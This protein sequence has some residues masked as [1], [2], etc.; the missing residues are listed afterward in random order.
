MTTTAALETTADDGTTARRTGF[1]IAADGSY[2]ACLATD[3]AENWYPERW[4]LGGPEPYTVPLPCAQ[5]EDSQ[6]TVLPL[7]DGRVLIRRLTDGRHQLSLLY[8]SGPATGEQ[9]CGAVEAEE[10]LLVPPAVDRGEV[11]ALAPGDASTKV[12]LVHGGGPGPAL[13][14]EVPGRCTGGRWLDRGGALLALDRE[15]DGRTKT[16][17]VDLSRAGDVTPLLQITDDSNDRLLLADPD[18]GLLLVRSDAPGEDRLGWGVLGSLRPV[19]FSLRVP[20][21]T[22]TPLAVQ[23]GQV[24]TPER[25]GVALRLD[26]PAG[27]WLGVWRPGDRELRHLPPP[28]GWVPGTALWTASG[29]LRLPYATEDQLCGLARITLP[30]PGPLPAAT[31]P[32]PPERAAARG[33]APPPPPAPAPPTPHTPR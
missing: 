21:A 29:E 13:A 20:G 30:D 7:P 5:P 33:P 1:T 32:A 25:C 14:A 4:T 2:A 31:L 26:G 6:S 12:W 3:R 22:L 16:V 23:P 11:Y 27:M 17:A 8:P 24:L 9:Q 10:L 19:R 18:S 15:L 28:L